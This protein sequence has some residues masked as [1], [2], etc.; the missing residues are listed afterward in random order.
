MARRYVDS[1]RHTIQVDYCTFTDELAKLMGV[2]PH[3]WR[4]M[5]KNPRLAYHLWFGPLLPY[6]FRL[7]GPH[8][9]EGARKAIVSVWDRV[10]ADL[11]Q[12]SSASKLDIHN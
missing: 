8:Q 3:A 7:E 4:Y 12:N 6:H 9:W 5:L 10:N 2:R 11:P 1:R